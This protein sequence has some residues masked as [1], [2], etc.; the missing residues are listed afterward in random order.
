MT[1]AKFPRSA[2]ASWNVASSRPKTAFSR[3]PGRFSVP[4]GRQPGLFGP[5]A[6][7]PAASPDL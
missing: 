5:R 6:R 3:A 7:P 2:A 4:P 1:S